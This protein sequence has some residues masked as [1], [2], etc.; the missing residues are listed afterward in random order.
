MACAHVILFEKW[1]VKVVIERPAISFTKTAE[2]SSP[3]VGFGT[4]S[5]RVDQANIADCNDFFHCSIGSSI[6]HWCLSFF[7]YWRYHLCQNHTEKKKID[8]VCMARDL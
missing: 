1:P 5:P 8:T 6:L 7:V 2:L 4:V 3:Q